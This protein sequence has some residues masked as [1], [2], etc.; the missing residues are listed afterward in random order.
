M[1]INI[2]GGELK[3]LKPGEIKDLQKE[4]TSKLNEIETNLKDLSDIGDAVENNQILA[5]LDPSE[6][7]ANLNQALARYDLASQALIRFQDLKKKGF[8]FPFHK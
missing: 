6:M 5:S 4:L 7:Q 1:S 2:S 8:I 3:E